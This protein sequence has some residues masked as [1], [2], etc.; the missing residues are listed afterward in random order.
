MTKVKICGVTCLEDI[1]YVNH[2]LPDYIG[3]L[4]VAGRRRSVS[5]EQAALL[6]KKLDRRICPVGVFQNQSFS[7]IQTLTRAGTVKAIQLHGQE[8]EKLISQLQQKTGLPVIKAF[9]VRSPQDIQAARRS[10]ADAALLDGSKAGS[11]QT[12]D[13]SL[14]KDMDRP[15]F[16]AGGLTPERVPAALAW[17]PFA[18]DVSSGVETNGKKDA[19]KIQTFINITRQVHKYE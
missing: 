6:V 10:T 16:L 15:F 8:S 18:L 11:G 7:F 1:Q 13:W 17:K 19:G 12:F 4:F 14:L 3:L 9:S 2:S 5:P